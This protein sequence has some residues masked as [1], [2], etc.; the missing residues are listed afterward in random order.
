MSLVY[1]YVRYS[2][3]KQMKGDGLRLQAEDGEK[4]I[5]VG[6]HASQS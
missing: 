5:G 1:S 3:K 6:G 4:W 2:S